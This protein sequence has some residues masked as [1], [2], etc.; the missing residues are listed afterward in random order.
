MAD[1][2]VY[3]SAAPVRVE[4]SG[5]QGIP[6]VALLMKP[7]VANVAALPASGNSTNDGRV[8]NDTG[9]AYRWTGSAW[10]L[11]GKFVGAQGPAGPIGPV[12]PAG[13]TDIVLPSYEPETFAYLGN[14]GID[15]A[16]AEQLDALIKG[17]KSLDA[18][19][20]C[21][22]WILDSRY[23]GAGT[24]VVGTG[25]VPIN[26]A[27]ENG[28]GTITESTEEYYF[29]RGTAR[30][31][32]PTVLM[33]TS[34]LMSLMM[35]GK[36]TQQGQNIGNYFGGR[37]SGF[38]GI[39]NSQPGWNEIGVSTALGGQGVMSFTNATQGGGSP[40]SA[41]KSVLLTITGERAGNCSINGGAVVA[42]T[43]FGADYSSTAKDTQSNI[44]TP[45]D[46][47]SQSLGSAA[48]SFVA[49]WRTNQSSKVTDIYNLYKSTI[50]SHLSLP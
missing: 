42:A 6:A 50:G 46:S 47:A 17:L 21:S 9:N 3:V 37:A 45:S 29:S 41:R 1:I 44:F 24:T 7:P 16:Y 14:T 15:F 38:V 26:G 13:P 20:D 4:V 2:D 36:F 10:I 5:A 43:S 23:Q 49:F 48:A 33:P 25:G 35:V 12:G 28:L 22:L 19:D 18:W 30:I 31:W 27:K 32:T 40:I 11:V 39:S 8:T 34:P